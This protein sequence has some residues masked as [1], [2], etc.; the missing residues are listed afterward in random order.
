MSARW[1]RLEDGSL[2]VVVRELEPVGLGERERAIVRRWRG[3]R[4]WLYT[5][6]CDGAKRVRPMPAALRRELAL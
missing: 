1:V 2:I 4:L 5:C 3:K 6:A